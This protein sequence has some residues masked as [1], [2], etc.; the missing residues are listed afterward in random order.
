MMINRIFTVV[1]SLLSL[2]LHAQ[3]GP[4]PKPG[5]FELT[6]KLAGL[7]NEKVYLYPIESPAA[8]DSTNAVNGKFRFAGRLTQPLLCVLRINGTRSQRGIFLEP[9]KMM[10]NGHKDSLQNA[11]IKGS[12]SNNEYS[13]WSKEWTRIASQAGPMYKR[14]DSATNQGKVKEPESERKIFEDGMQS[15]NDQTTKAVEAFIKKYPQSPVGPFIIYD[16][17]ISY[18]NPE[19]ARS[20]FSMLGDKAKNSNYGKKITEYQRIAAKTGIGASPDFTVADTSGKLFKLSA[21]RGKYVLVDFWASWCVP[22][23]KENPNVVKAYQAFHD[24][25][26]E[27]VGVSLDTKKDAWKKAIEMDSL[28]WNHVSD[29][30]GWESGIVKEFGITVVPTS[31][32]VGPDG[33]VMANNLRAE[34]LHKKLGELLN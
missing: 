14:L 19:L 13:E 27:I 21:L 6:G 4:K 5:T 22:C 10:I 11:T 18:P 1:L 8:L 3:P 25:G 32:L 29:L 28:K 17:Y 9:G 30:K 26:F 16:R 7:T 24:K 2:Q 33:K 31:F 20:M 34:A 23:R 15:L 12:Q